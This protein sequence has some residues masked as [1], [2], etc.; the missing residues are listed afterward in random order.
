MP[1]TKNAMTRYALID[2]MLANRTRPYSIQDITDTLNEKLQEFGQKSVSKRC[3][4]KDLYYLEY[5]SPF[6]VEI[7]EYW[8]D[9]ADKNDRPYRKRCIRYV[10][11]TFSIFKQKL[12]DDEKNVLSIALD[13][14]G[15]FEGLDNFEWLND[16]T[17]RLNLEQH[18]SIISLSKNLLTNSTLIA[19]LFTV[20]RFKH[21]IT[22]RYHTFRNE[23]M[24]SVCVSP[25]LL[26]EYNNRW[27]LIASASDTG[28]ILTFPLD[29]IDDFSVN[30]NV[31]YLSA[32]ENLYERY[33]EIIGVT[34][35]EDKPIQKIIFWV[36][37]N[38]KD[39]VITKPLHGSQKIIRGDMY[40]ELRRTYPKLN[41]GNF[42]QIE[43][44]ENYE[45]LRELTSFGPNLLVIY[46]NSVSMLVINQVTEL[47]NAYKELFCPGGELS[48]GALL[49]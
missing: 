10:D 26:K 9:A 49:D 8:I 15:S 18:E 29:R 32:P 17:V 19:R 40:S 13:T 34:Y 12:T 1:A 11:P 35:K 4:E 21:V 38:S 23:E 20:I 25:Y 3:V 39:Y 41:N 47:S 36:S 6:D 43:C 2:R 31:T 24:R 27:F 48:E 14:L 42:F 16:L 33:E 7:E 37:E 28:R 30:T 5:D 45:L 44:R 46:P 22:L